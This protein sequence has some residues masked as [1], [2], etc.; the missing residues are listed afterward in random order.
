M[1][2]PSPGI[3][4]VHISNSHAMCQDRCDWFQNDAAQPYLKALHVEQVS[5]CQAGNSFF[6]IH[7]FL[8]HCGPLFGH[9][10]QL[11]ESVDLGDPEHRY[12]THIYVLI[13]NMT[14]DEPATDFRVILLR[15]LS[16]SGFGRP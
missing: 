8:V 15:D 12:K 11:L 7:L 5:P 1:P 2:V 4:Q 9:S 13:Q 16:L 6:L 3:E 10:N 14:I